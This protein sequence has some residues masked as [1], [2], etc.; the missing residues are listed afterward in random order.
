VGG[1]ALAVLLLL[2]S[3]QLRRLRAAGSDELAMLESEWRTVVR[4]TSGERR[5]TPTTASALS[6]A[7][8][9]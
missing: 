3:A 2:T 8:R 6:G 5:A 4:R 7:E 1:G 9:R